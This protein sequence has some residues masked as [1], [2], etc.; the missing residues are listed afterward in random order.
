FRSGAI[1]VLYATD[2]AG[3]GCNVPNVAYVALFTDP[4][5]FSTLVQRWGRAGWDRKINGTCLLFLPAWAFR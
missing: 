1:R 3:M 4:S 2:A 5:T